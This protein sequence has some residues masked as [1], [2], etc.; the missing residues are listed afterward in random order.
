MAIIFSEWKL[1]IIWKHT[2]KNREIGFEIDINAFC[3]FPGVKMANK[4][5]NL[6]EMNT[7]FSRRSASGKCANVPL[8]KFCI[9]C[10][11]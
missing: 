10:R 5:K 11:L 1:E 4:Y 9:L 2:S 3:I 7:Y 6:C 8:P